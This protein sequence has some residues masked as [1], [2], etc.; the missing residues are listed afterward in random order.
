MSNVNVLGT[1]VLDWI[2]ENI[3]GTCIVKFDIHGILS[4]SIITQ[5][6]LHP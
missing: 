5:Q 1:R 4:E 2:L 3:D 6:L